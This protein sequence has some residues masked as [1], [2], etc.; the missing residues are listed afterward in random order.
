[1][2]LD[3]LRND[4]AVKQKRGLHFI[5]SS[6]LIWIAV[7]VIHMTSM[8]ILTKN[9]LTFCSTAPLLPLAFLVSKVIK[10]DFHGNGNPLTK[11]GMLFSL[12]QMLYLLIVMWVYPTVP[13]KMLMVL[14]MIFGAHLLPY[15]WLYK[16][17]SY[18][19]FAVVIPVISLIIGVFFEPYILALSMV[20]IELFFSFC[21]VM[22]NL[23]NPLK[24][25]TGHV[26]L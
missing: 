4:C 7:S 15:G 19:F 21:L 25:D 9:L 16:S 2:N 5:L 8:P 13:D 3:D 23:K 18:T 1:M 20:A 14:S 11:L 26:Q 10:A 22:E 24:T 12:N 17:R 6:V